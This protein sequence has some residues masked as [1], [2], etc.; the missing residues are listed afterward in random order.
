[1]QVVMREGTGRSVYRYLGEDIAVAGKTGTSNDQRDSWFSGFGD[2]YLAVVWLG[3]DDNGKMPF[4]GSSGALQ[5]WSELMAGLKVRPLAFT[6]PDNIT[7]HWVDPRVGLLSEE[8]CEGARY[9][10]FVA[11]SEP[12]ESV[13]CRSWRGGQFIDWFKG[14]LK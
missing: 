10:P 6:R 11:G 14:L 5:L 2:D 9:I 12:V 13:A 1:M 3:R 4:T 8:G 7:Y